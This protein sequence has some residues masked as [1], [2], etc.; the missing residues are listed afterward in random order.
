LT[1]STG[2]GGRI[3]TKRGGRPPPLTREGLASELIPPLLLVP[4]IS[5]GEYQQSDNKDDDNGDE[6][7]LGHRSS[8]C[9]VRNSPMLMATSPNRIRVISSAVSIVQIY[10]INLEPPNKV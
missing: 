2:G 6:C 1:D 5:A 3:R 4:L 10:N 7:D 8:M 9:L